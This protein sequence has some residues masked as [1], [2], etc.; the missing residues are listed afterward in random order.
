MSAVYSGYVSSL[1]WICEQSTMDVSTVYGGYVR[2]K[3]GCII[4]SF[5][6][7]DLK[8]ISLDIPNDNNS[9]TNKAFFC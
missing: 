3:R 4:N 7:P 5:F 9:N 1:W 2:A 8:E 6:C